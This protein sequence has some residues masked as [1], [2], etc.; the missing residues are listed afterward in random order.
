MTLYDIKAGDVSTTLKATQKA[1][2]GFGKDLQPL[3]G[4]AKAAATACGD[5]GA[6]V[7]ALEGLFKYESTTLTNMSNHIAACLTG[8]AAATVAYIE[9]D[10][11]MV[12]TYQKNAAKGISSKVPKLPKK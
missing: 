10:L 4:Y 2:D 3:D 8:A 7:P 6:V 5:S 11:D 1:A 9:G 12:Q